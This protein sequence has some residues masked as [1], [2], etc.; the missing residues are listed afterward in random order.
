MNTQRKFEDLT[1]EDFMVIKGDVPKQVRFSFIQNPEKLAEKH[2][3][4]IIDM[5]G[6]IFVCI[7]LNMG[8]SAVNFEQERVRRLNEIIA[9][10]ANA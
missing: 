2:N 10:R 5:K 4:P 1:L 7:A 3:L 6:V 9:I 8:V